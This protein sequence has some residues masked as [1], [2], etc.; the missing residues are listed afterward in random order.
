[1]VDSKGTVNEE[2]KAPTASDNDA[3]KG[4]SGKDATKGKDVVS[5]SSATPSKRTPGVKEVPPFKWKLIGES[6]DAVL[7]LFKAVERSEVETQ[8]E[9]ARM[10]GYYSKLRVADIDEKT[11]Q[12]AS[13]KRLTAT[14]T[15]AKSR[16]RRSKPTAAKATK[17]A[18]KTRSP[19]KAAS[20]SS[21]SV[22]TTK[23]VK[24]AK[25]TKKAVKTTKS[26]KTRR[27][28]TPAKG[29]KRKSATAKATRKR[30]PKKR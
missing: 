25:K 26:A 7:T 14:K 19:K 5:P 27:S 1:M 15:A 17:A 4:E 2:P 24:R 16:Q 10:E 12:P 20:K 29:P 8:Y 6:R 23:G 13:A 21:R 30:A 9:R 18:S 3:K 11:V 22:K 28:K